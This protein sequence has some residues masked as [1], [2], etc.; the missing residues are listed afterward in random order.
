MRNTI[1]IVFDELTSYQNLPSDII[2]NLK[3]YQ[4]FKKKCIEFNNIQT[5]RQQCTPSRSTIITG[6][7]DTSC[8]DNMEFN[9][10]Y[11]YFPSIPTDLNTIGKIYKNN[12]YDIT[13]YYGKQHLDS[14]LATDVNSTPTFNTATTESMK[15]Y[16]Y[17]KFNV[18]GDTYYHQTK[19]LLSDNQVISYELPPN[20]Q[21]YDY[22]ENNSKYSG[23][24]PFLKARIVDK[25]SYYLECHITNPHDTNHFIQNLTQKPAGTMNEFPTPFIQNQINEAQIANPYYFNS[26]NP[27]AVP[28]HPN[29]LNN[30]FE[31]VYS[32]Y[33]TNKFTL[34]FLTSYELDYATNPIVNSLNP[35]MIGT[36]YALRYNMTISDSQ[37][38]VKDWKNFLN[39]Y[40]GLVFEADSY[41]EKLY[42]FFESNGIFESSNII[43]ISDHGDLLSSHGLKQKQMP[44]KECSNVVCLIHSP[45]LSPNLIGRNS[46]LYGSLVDILPTQLLLNNL[47]SESKFDGKS[48]LVW[49]CNKLKINTQ[50]HLYYN[51]INIVNSTMYTLNYFF[52]L[53]W[54]KK[55][56][57]SQTLTFN[58]SNMFE[59]QSS[60]VSVITNID[61]HT[62][63]FG[64]Y[65]SI[66]S[67][68]RYQLFI[69]QNQDI[70]NK[71]EFVKYINLNSMFLSKRCSIEYVVDNFPHVFS[72]ES[73][74]N[75]LYSDFGNNDI[76]LYY[77]YYAFIANKLNS[78]TDFAY[79]IPGSMSDWN[80]NEDLNIFSYFL[81]DIDTDPS[82]SINLMDVKNIQYI[83]LELKNNLNHILNISLREKN[84]FQIK[85][86]LPDITYLQI[87]ELLYILGGFTFSL[88][89]ELKY[90]IL[91]TINGLNGLDAQIS[92]RTIQDFNGYIKKNINDINSSD[93]N[94][95]Y[96]LYDET[97]GIYYIGEYE[98]IE[99]ISHNM[100]YFAN[101]AMNEGLPNIANNKFVIESNNILPRLNVYKIV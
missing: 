15:I 98:Y 92:D 52:Y 91:G 89:E 20:S 17:D 80:T 67:T 24:I 26:A 48:L 79:Y 30:Y 27:Y 61:G 40:Y 10:Q 14:K 75:I 58:P 72:F 66:Y 32:A 47:N 93:I 64:R 65:Y 29:L 55:N 100:P 4:L 7:Y 49:D 76:Y 2:D 94:N 22:I 45:D 28:T 25:K 50:E 54:Y 12:N 1:L 21:V 46:N 85:T 44:F 73:G 3:G 86:I 41:L 71:I 33:K 68:I 56:Y 39:N 36:Y 23:V 37:D 63:K 13:T 51:P 88:F 74:L 9:Y 57:N 11:E 16:G 96:N 6:I 31:P 81:Y 60:F 99:F 34:P 53:L 83:N 78:L 69:N 59:F 70:F 82:E 97:N 87:S 90:I 84:C 38:D 18:F 95:P 5:A 42:Y 62:F 19:G 77:T 8:Q 43:I 35:L 101:F